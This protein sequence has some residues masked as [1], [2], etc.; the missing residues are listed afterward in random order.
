MGKAQEKPVTTYEK[1]RIKDP[2]LAARIKAR[3]KHPKFSRAWWTA[4]YRKEPLK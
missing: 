3:R 2:R 1:H 4:R